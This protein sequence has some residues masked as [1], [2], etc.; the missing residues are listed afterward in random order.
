MKIFASGF[1]TDFDGP[2]RRMVYY[3]KGC[4]LYCPWCSNPESLSNETSIAYYPERGT[5]PAH[6][7]PQKAIKEN[8]LEREKCRKCFDRLCS[9][10]WKSKVIE[11][12]GEDISVHKI[13]QEVESKKHLLTGGGVTFTGGE[14]TLQA[15]E[16]RDALIKL[17]KMGIHTA[18]E[19]NGTQPSLTRLI[20]HLD[21]LIFDF[22]CASSNRH[23]I[24]TGS[25]NEAIK[26]MLYTAAETGINTDPKEQKA[27]ISFLNDFKTLAKSFK[28]Q[29]SRMHHF[30]KSKYQALD[31]EYKAEDFI[32]PAA[33]ELN[34]FVEA[35][36][37]EG[38]P[39]EAI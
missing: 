33:E 12:I 15:V 11:I 2:G 34:S 38:L 22:K 28:I 24:W 35:M 1:S 10:T 16:L 3:L 9:D 27:I 30:G 25:K 26:S 31:M 19:T 17:Q 23:K 37:H 7:C 18:I 5:L 39:A 21:L 14:P 32:I 29:I 20:P 6:I 4:N 13:C 8:K 36:Q